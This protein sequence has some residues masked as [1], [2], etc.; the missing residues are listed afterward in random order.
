M[1][2]EGDVFDWGNSNKAVIVKI[3]DEQAGSYYCVYHQNKIKYVVAYFI[4]S[5]GIW[6][7]TNESG[8]H[9]KTGEYSIYIGKLSNNV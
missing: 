2:K 4:Y 3:L 5:D 8:R 1:F 9:I 6:S 7:I